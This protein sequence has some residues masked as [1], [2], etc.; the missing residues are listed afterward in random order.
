MPPVDS[1]TSMPFNY[2]LTWF[3]ESSND[4]TLPNADGKIKYLSRMRGRC[5]RS[6]DRPP[7]SASRLITG[8]SAPPRPAEKGQR[9]DRASAAARLASLELTCCK[10]ISN[11]AKQDILGTCGLGPDSSI[12]D[13]LSSFPDRAIGA[14]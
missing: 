13:W 14:A 12:S 7:F 8:W 3:A 1:V 9:N 11:G 6:T 2:N 5:A 10:C 4:C